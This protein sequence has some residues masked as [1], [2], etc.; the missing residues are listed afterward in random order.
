[1]GLLTWLK[2]TFGNSDASDTVPFYDFDA[3]KVVRIPR[4]ELSSSAIQVQIR[5][6]DGVVWVLPDKLQQGS[7][8]HGPFSEEIRGYLRQIQAA[9]AEHRDLTLEE[10]EDGF[11]RDATPEREIAL[12]SHAADIYE[13]FTDGESS[14]DRRA[15]V[16]R[17]I[18]TCMTTGPDSVW[19]VLRP[20]TLERSFAEEVVNRFYGKRS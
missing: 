5:G 14:A 2:R 13:Q 16:Y 8:Q 19:D 18:V 1:M 11:R 17:C 12:W 3:G 4:C 9:F 10:W 7:H 6:M 15:D 20:Q